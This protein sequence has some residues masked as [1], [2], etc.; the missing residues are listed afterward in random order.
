MDE[1][2]SY[3]REAMV[4]EYA[5]GKG[6]I[7]GGTPVPAGKSKGV[8][9]KYDERKVYRISPASLLADVGRCATNS[10][11]YMQLLVTVAFQPRRFSMSLAESKRY[12]GFKPRSGGSG[13]S[14]WGG[15]EAEKGLPLR[16][17]RATS[18]TRTP[19]VSMAEA[20]LKRPPGSA[21]VSWTCLH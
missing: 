7:P 17:R 4:G 10:K 1:D 19:M 16:E 18:K 20:F 2:V 12:L 21:R 11:N 14:G 13:Q 9:L 15:G 6:K 3:S 5:K 8:F